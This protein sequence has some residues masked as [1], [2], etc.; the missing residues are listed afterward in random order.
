MTRLGHSLLQGS[1]YISITF[2]AYSPPKHSHFPVV[3]PVSGLL[4][5]HPGATWV[6]RH[7]LLGRHLFPC[8]VSV[9]GL[10]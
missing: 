7:F 1:V 2:S 9:L 10:P 3:H 4:L 5:F 6:V 8:Y